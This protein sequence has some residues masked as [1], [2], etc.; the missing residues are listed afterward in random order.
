[1]NIG[2]HISF[3][4]RVFIFS[5]Y[6]PRSGIAKCYGSFIF[7]FL[8]NFHT[9]LHSGCTNLHSYQQCRNVPFSLQ[10]LQHLFFVDFLRTTI[11]TS[12]RWYLIVVL[13]C[14]SLIIFSDIKHIFLGLLLICMCSFG[15]CLFKS[16]AHFLVGFFVLYWAVWAVYIFWQLKPSKYCVKRM[17]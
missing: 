6:I 9:V 17:V 8:S 2:V 1:M 5:I 16:S 11:L 4:I 15:K 7:S 13:I 14:I 12:V 3:W 10:P